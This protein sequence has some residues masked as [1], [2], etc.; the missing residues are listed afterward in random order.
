M[1][2]LQVWLHPSSRTVEQSSVASRQSLAKSVIRRKLSI[3]KLHPAPLRRPAAIVRNR[4]E[5]LDR[6]DFDPRGGE[7][8]N[9]RLAA[10]ARAA[11]ADTD[12][13]PA[14]I[15]SHVGGVRSGLLRGE[16]RALARS[17]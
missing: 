14:V 1:T 2:G 3:T 17:T 8:A 5:V 4:R 13:A 7:S 15:A 6:P 10:G 11:D 16:G 12:R 9:C